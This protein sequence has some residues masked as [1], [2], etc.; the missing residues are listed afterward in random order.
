MRA[1]KQGFLIL[2]IAIRFCELYSCLVLSLGDLNDN[3]A[4]DRRQCDLEGTGV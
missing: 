3:Q 1:V 2:Q 4:L